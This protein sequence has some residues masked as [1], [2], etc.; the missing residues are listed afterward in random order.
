MPKVCRRKA[1][2]DVYDRLNAMDEWVLQWGAMLT[3][4][5]FL[6]FRFSKNASKIGQI[7]RLIWRLIIGKYGSV[8][9]LSISVLKVKGVRW[10]K[11]HLISKGNLSVSNS[12]KKQTWKCQFFSP[13]YWSKKIS[14]FIWK[15][16]KK[17]K[18]L[19][20]LTVL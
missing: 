8:E 12:P 11:G 9:K 2:V 19:L 4:S 20:K 7:F 16:W 15:N 13:A 6:Q 1:K 17:Q 18:S 3:K 10:A 14:F 5:A